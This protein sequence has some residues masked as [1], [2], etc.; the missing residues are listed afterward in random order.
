MET[1]PQ[2]DMF[3]FFLPQSV[4]LEDSVKYLKLNLVV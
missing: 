1:L 2:S 3:F 4:C